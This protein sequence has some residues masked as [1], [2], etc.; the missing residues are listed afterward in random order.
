MF[1]TQIQEKNSTYTKAVTGEILF[2]SKKK[3]SLLIIPNFFSRSRVAP[4]VRCLAW[5]L[6]FLKIS[7][8]NVL[9]FKKSYPYRKNGKKTVL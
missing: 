4:G 5:V 2:R 9:S 1:L 7:R 3:S 8:K 6:L